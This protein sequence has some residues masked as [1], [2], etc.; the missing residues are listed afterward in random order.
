[1]ISNDFALR[2]LIRFLK[3]KYNVF[4][5]GR[6]FNFN[7]HVLLSAPVGS[8][9]PSFYIVFKKH[10]F[11]QSFNYSF[12]QFTDENPQFKGLGESINLEFLKKKIK[13]II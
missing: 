2:D 11:F 13:K 3:V 9:L 7:R 6:V 8:D 5:T 4:F 10:G 12:K 1:M